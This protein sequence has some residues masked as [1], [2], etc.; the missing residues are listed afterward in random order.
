M[1]MAMVNVKGW[2]L[3]RRPLLLSPRSLV[4]FLHLFRAVSFLRMYLDCAL[5][6]L[7]PMWIACSKMTNT[8]LNSAPEQKMFL[9]CG[10]FLLSITPAFTVTDHRW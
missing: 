5:L 4:Q 2:W 3:G 10:L 6:G 9:A 7:G 8:R 1:A